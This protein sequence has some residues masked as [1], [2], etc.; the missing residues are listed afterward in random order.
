MLKQKF[1][2]IDEK[3]D[4]PLANMTKKKRKNHKLLIWGTKSDNV[5]S[6]SPDINE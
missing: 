5:F 2:K 4:I 3:I 6:L 1:N